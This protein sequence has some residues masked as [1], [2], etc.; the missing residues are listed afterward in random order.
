MEEFR[1]DNDARA[2]K[3]EDFMIQEALTA[4]VIKASKDRKYKNPNRWA[5]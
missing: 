3:I 4:G 1:E 5:K 2:A